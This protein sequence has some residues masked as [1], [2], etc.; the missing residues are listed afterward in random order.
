MSQ[1]RSKQI[2]YPLLELFVGRQMD[3][4]TMQG[5][6]RLRILS[7]TFAHHLGL[8]K[9]HKIPARDRWILYS[10]AS[11]E[12]KANI[13]QHSGSLIKMHSSL[14]MTSKHIDNC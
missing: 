6:V 9:R 13:L 7:I 3:R 4:E 8:N 1:N 12:L 2:Y 10:D 14:G 5:L 11:L